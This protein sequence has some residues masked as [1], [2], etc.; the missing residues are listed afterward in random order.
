M[1]AH[2]AGVFATDLAAGDWGQVTAT[3]RVD[4]QLLADRDHRSDQRAGAIAELD[5][6]LRPS[7]LHPQPRSLQRAIKMS[8][9][10]TLISTVRDVAIKIQNADGTAFKS[11]GVAPPAA[12]TRIKALH[13]TSDDT[14]AQVAAGLQDHRRRRLPARRDRVAIGAGSTARRTR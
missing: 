10:P 9:Q 8:A 13:I 2:T 3:H 12:G 14:A 11:L 1:V 4:D 7:H 5:N 6:E